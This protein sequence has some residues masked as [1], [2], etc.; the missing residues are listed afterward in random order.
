MAHLNH[1]DFNKLDFMLRNRQRDDISKN[2]S[3]SAREVMKENV[4]LPPPSRPSNTNI[5]PPPVTHAHASGNSLQPLQQIYPSY[6]P[7]G[8]WNPY[9]PFVGMPVVPYNS[10]GMTPTA[11]TS[12]IGQNSSLPPP[13]VGFSPHP[14]GSTS[15]VLP[16]ITTCEYLDH[17]MLIYNY[18]DA[19]YS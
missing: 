5:P 7:P 16:N 3:A 13:S 17:S 8:F 15:Q 11:K 12:S 18:S 2:Q 19:R 10:L 6:A 1:I 14:N 4:P 9:A